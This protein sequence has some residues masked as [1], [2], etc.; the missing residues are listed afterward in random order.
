MSPCDKWYIFW[1]IAP[2][3]GTVTVATLQSL[4][5]LTLVLDSGSSEESFRSALSRDSVT[6]AT[7]SKQERR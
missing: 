1:V 2:Y 5:F 6:T 3:V 7:E 4:L